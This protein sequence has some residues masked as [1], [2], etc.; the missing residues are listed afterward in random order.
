M[1]LPGRWWVVL[2]L[3]Y[4]M[5]GYTTSSRLMSQ[6]C[7]ARL[8]ARVALSRFHCP[9]AT[10]MELRQAPEPWRPLPSL[11]GRIKRFAL[12]RFF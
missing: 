8:H 6:R 7:A 10:G 5:R 12:R 1:A 9:L 11:R 3:G 4:D 2:S